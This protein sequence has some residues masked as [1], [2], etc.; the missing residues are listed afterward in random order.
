[1]LERIRRFWRPSADDGLPPAPRAQRLLMAAAALEVTLVIG[2]GLMM[3]HVEF[4]RARQTADALKPCAPGQPRD[5][6]GGVMGVIVAPP[7][8]SA[9]N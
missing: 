5:C 6:V 2:A 7:A 9:R 8:S 3:P 4:L 1:M